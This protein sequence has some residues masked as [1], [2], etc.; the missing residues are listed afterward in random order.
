MHM[1]FTPQGPSQPSPIIPNVCSY[2]LLDAD[3]ANEYYFRLSRLNW[4]EPETIIVEHKWSEPSSY[5]QLS[6]TF[7]EFESHPDIQSLKVRAEE[8]LTQMGYDCKFNQVIVHWYKDDLHC[9]EDLDDDV[10]TNNIVAAISLGANRHV[11]IINPKTQLQSAM[12]TENGTLSIINGLIHHFN[13]S[14]FSNP[15]N[16]IAVIFRTV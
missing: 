4:G 3:V 14:R 7:T 1:S 10:D 9:K 12:V 13:I 5:S 6:L 15:D 11:T 8:K 16:R 2:K